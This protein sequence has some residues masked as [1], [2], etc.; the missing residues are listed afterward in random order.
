M[1]GHTWVISNTDY[2]VDLSNTTYPPQVS[3]SKIDFL[4]IASTKNGKSDG[5]WYSQTATGEIPDPRTDFCIVA[6]SAPDNSSHNIYLYGGRG[7]N[8]LY[9]QIYVLSIPSFTWMKVAEG[10]SPR[11]GH[12]CHVVG[13]K[14]MVTVG[15]DASWDLVTGCDWELKGLAIMDMSTF[16]WGSVYNAYAGNY[17]V[18][19]QI[20]S[21]IGGR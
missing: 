20:Y 7:A 16:E 2:I 21:V 18:P 12:T 13:Q 3:F 10:K 15:G 19:S 5:T 9:D 8:D 6:A 4:D 14:Q 11:Y 17:Q 1:K